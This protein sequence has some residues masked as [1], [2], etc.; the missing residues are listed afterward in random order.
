M[1]FDCAWRSR[2]EGRAFQ[3]RSNFE[4]NLIKN[5]IQKQKSKTTRFLSEFCPQNAPKIDPK[6]APKMREKA[7]PDHQNITIIF[8]RFWWTILDGF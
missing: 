7:S 6:R 8:D 3:N 2:I 4:Q 5:R 1:R